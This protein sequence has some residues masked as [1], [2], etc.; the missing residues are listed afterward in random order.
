MPVPSLLQVCSLMLDGRPLENCLRCQRSK[1]AG[2]F[3]VNQTRQGRGPWLQDSRHSGPSGSSER[4]ARPGRRARRGNFCARLGHYLRQAFPRPSPVLSK[5]KGACMGFLVIV[6]HS[7]RFI[8]S[9]QSSRTG[10]SLYLHVGDVGMLCCTACGRCWS[11]PN[12][13]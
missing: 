12:L 10:Q 11:S 3:A 6:E 2:G 7:E 1:S 8:F 5:P 4:G 13:P 9:D